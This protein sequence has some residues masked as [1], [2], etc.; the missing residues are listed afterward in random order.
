LDSR[1]PREWQNRAVARK[2]SFTDFS[3]FILARLYDLDQTERSGEY[4]DIREI[5]AELK[6]PVPHRWPADALTTLRDQGLADG[7]LAGGSTVEGFITGHGRLYVEEREREE[8]V[9]REYRE[10]PS[11]IVVVSGTGHQVA[12]DTR[13][14]VQQ[15]SINIDVP[16]EVWSLLN[17]IE[18]TLAGDDSLD[19][20]ERETAIEEV[21]IARSQLQKPEPNKRAAA[22]ILDPLAKFSAVAGFVLKVGELL[23]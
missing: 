20:A 4:I 6:E 22:A 1:T 8:G 12:V 5:A 10:R 16:A 14:N 3:E 23:S 2:L 13:G 9:I 17:Q 19:P 15:T 11:S 21:R 7:V 18:G